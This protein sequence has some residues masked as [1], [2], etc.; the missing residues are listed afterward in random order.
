[1]NDRIDGLIEGLRKREDRIDGLI[2]RLRK[3]EDVDCQAAAN[4]LEQLC[5]VIKTLRFVVGCAEP[6]HSSNPESQA[7]QTRRFVDS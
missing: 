1:M 7:Q 2:E 4:E 3:R 6:S 5:A